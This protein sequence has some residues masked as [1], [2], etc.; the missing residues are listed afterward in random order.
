MSLHTHTHAVYNRKACRSF[1]CYPIPIHRHIFDMLRNIAGVTQDTSADLRALCLSC[2]GSYPSI[3]SAAL[4]MRHTRATR[5]LIRPDSLSAPSSAASWRRRLAVSL[6]YVRRLAECR[7][8]SS[9]RTFG[10]NLV[11]SQTVRPRYSCMRKGFTEFA[12]SV[13]MVSTAFRP[14]LSYVFLLQHVHI[15]QDA[16]MTDSYAEQSYQHGVL[17]NGCSKL[18]LEIQRPQTWNIRPG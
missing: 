13:S 17:N 2:N 5:A 9:S 4:G 12:I 6:L 3:H 7:L 18:I 15:L 11:F 14:P 1:L 8:G 16:S 10:P